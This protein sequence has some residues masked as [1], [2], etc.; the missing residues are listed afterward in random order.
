ME[1]VH[2]YTGDDGRSHFADVEL[3][4]TTSFGSPL[5]EQLAGVQGMGMRDVPAGF[6]NGFHTAPRRQ[7]VVNLRGSG[8]ITCGDGSSRTLGPGDVMLCD[9]TTGEGHISR[10][11]VGPR[12]QL[13]VYL[14]PE[15]DL[16]TIFAG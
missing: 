8:E 1:I 11:L 12:R 4:V 15:L 7:L 5:F 10:E 3:V 9:D 16:R 2:L 13:Y 6:S 14:D